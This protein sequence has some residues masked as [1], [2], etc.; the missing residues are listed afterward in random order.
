MK[1]GRK[2]GAL[3]A[4]I[5]RN[6]GLHFSRKETPNAIR[7]STM[8][9]GHFARAIGDTLKTQDNAKGAGFF[10]ES[11]PP[12]SIGFEHVVIS[13]DYFPKKHLASAK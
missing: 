3:Y 10:I 11:S 5:K 13:S 12:S 4:K 2:G 1:R 7:D 9:Q 6:L 8:S